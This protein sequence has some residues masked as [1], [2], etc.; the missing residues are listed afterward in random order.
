[1][2]TQVV[3]MLLQ[4]TLDGLREAV[5]AALSSVSSATIHRHS[6]HCMWIVDA[7]ES[8]ATYGTKE[9]KER[10]YSSQRQIVDKSKWRYQT[11]SWKSYSF[12]NIGGF[13]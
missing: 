1:M 10:V 9:F 13:F 11:K 2:V 6:L 12:V 5:P 4:Y 8:G 3:T 7:Y